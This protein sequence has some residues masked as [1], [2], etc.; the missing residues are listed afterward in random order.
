MNL[1]NGRFLGIARPVADGFVTLTGKEV[2]EIP[3]L[4]LFR[5]LEAVPTNDLDACV[6]VSEDPFKR[7]PC[8][9]QPVGTV[10]AQTDAVPPS[11]TQEVNDFLAVR[12][13]PEMHGEEGFGEF[14]HPAN[15]EPRPLGGCSPRSNRDQ[16]HDPAGS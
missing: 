11:T 3:F 5:R 16:T 2:H 14:E 9:R 13:G 8:P 6:V 4:H 15:L 12:I 1:T 10:L 7:H